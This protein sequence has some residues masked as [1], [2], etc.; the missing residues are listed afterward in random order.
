MFKIR[1]ILGSISLIFLLIIFEAI[2]RRKFMEKYALLWIL[3]GI[4]VFILSVFPEPLFKIAQ[5]SG[6]Y[7]LTVLLIFSFTF[8]LLIVLYLSISLSKLAE[9][10]KELAQEIGILKLKLDQ[11]E[12]ELQNEQNKSA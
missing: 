5:I 12:K 7:Y 1:V 9:N 3:S 4:L 10:N 11:L 2:R 8:L 6:L